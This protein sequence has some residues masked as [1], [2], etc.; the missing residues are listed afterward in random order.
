[1]C[2]LY[3]GDYGGVRELARTTLLIV[4]DDYVDFKYNNLKLFTN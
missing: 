3:I 4:N 1:M 2:L